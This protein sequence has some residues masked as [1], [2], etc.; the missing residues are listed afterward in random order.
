VRVLSMSERNPVLASDEIIVTNMT[1]PELGAAL[2][3]ALA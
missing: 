3:V 1:R 2:D